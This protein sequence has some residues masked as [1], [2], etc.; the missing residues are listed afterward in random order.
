[1]SEPIRVLH[2]LQRMEAAGV[3]TLLMNLYRKIDRNKVQFD[4][5][6]HYSTPQFFDKEIEELGGRIY[7][8]SVREDYNLIKYYR[9]LNAFFREH[10][11]YK[12][13]HGHMHTLGAIYLH[14]AKKY[15]VPI[16]IAHAHTN[17]T[18]R[19]KKMLLKLLMNRLYSVEANYL[20]ACSDAA[21]KYMFG[22]KPFDVI[23][24]AIITDDFVF[25]KIVRNKK[26][27]EL[28]VDGCLV[29]GNVGRFEIQKNQ[30]FTVEVFEEILKKHPNSVLLLIGT[31][32]M[33]NEIKNIVLERDL[34][35]KVKF[36]GNRRDVA[37]L[38]QAM[39]VFLMPSLFE[40]LG[41]V[42]VEAQA[43]GTPL[44]CS[45]TLPKE[46]DVSPLIY[47]ISLDEGSDVWA[48]VVVDASKDDNAHKDM[49]RH[50]VEA[51]Y[52]MSGLAEKM[53]RFYLEKYKK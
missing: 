10:K 36:L 39:D 48:K 1:M 24:N 34:Q 2:V 44:V 15:N 18:Q 45:N 41:I 52:D 16:R 42:G 5:L 38:Y 13:V 26:R 25:S 9:E 4:F 27:N 50:I 7:R 11:E 8:L 37:A 35:N 19:D 31:G 12:V 49:K 14:V 46:I 28:G 53:Q 3:Q 51:E 21:G 43:A 17:G 22:T 40:G 47:R 32:S 23:N 29:I 30:R 20:F 33:E 6:V